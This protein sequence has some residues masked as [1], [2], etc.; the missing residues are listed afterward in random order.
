LQ[1]EGEYQFTYQVTSLCNAGFEQTYLININALSCFIS[2][3]SEDIESATS[4]LGC[5]NYAGDR[6]YDI[7]DNTGNLVYSI[8]PGPDNEIA[9]ACWGKRNVYTTNPPRTTTID[10][11][12]V[13]FADRN[14]YLEPG[15]VTIGA[16]PVRIRLY[17]DQFELNRL[18]DYLKTNGFPNA[19]L[20]DLRILKKSAGAGSPV[21]LD[22]TFNAG[23]NTALYNIITPTVNPF[24]SGGD[25]YFEFEVNSFSEL[26]LVFTNGTTLPVTWL[27]VSAEMSNANALIKWSTASE[28][29]TKSFTVEH[30]EDGLK[31][32]SLYHVLAAGNSNTVK[33][34]EWIHTTPKQGMN[35]YRIKQIDRD[36]AYSYS[37]IIPIRFGGK[38]GNPEIYPNPVRDE[39]MV[40]L[41]SSGLQPMQYRVVNSLGQVVMEGNVGTGINP[42]RIRTAKL[43][44]G[45]YWLVLVTENELS[46]LK[47][48]KQ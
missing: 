10:G 43:S 37:Q 2:F 47:F 5:K 17:Y 24:G 28:M 14:F 32:V 18:L 41:P 8:N 29:N 35:Y 26:A 40:N 30:S 23:S 31:F 7:L 27:S 11:S 13:Y 33:R 16:N 38:P 42:I 48:L 6:W 34:Y 9:G 36:G 3:S 22:I 45:Y 25:Y 20:N 21:D 39:L 15:S 1:A 12:V 4:S 46:H 19:T 44:N